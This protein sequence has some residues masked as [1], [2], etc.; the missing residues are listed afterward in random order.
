MAIRGADPNGA[1][2]RGFWAGADY[3]AS[4]GP[5]ALTGWFPRCCPGLK[6]SAPLG[7]CELKLVPFGADPETGAKEMPELAR[8][9]FEKVIVRQ[10]GQAAA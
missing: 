3:V 5:A 10:Y 9:A 6:Y 8:K 4:S 7:H 1:N 2:L